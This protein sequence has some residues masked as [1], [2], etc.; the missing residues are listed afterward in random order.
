MPNTYAETSR[1]TSSQ[2]KDQ[3]SDM[4]G[5]AKEKAQEFGHAA[6][7]KIDEKRE[8]AADRLKGAAGGLEST[9]SYLREHDAKRILADIGSLVKRYPAQSILAAVTLGF[10]VGRALR[11]A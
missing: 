10:L 5:R 11:N 2:I 4:A 1:T 8:S 7:A 3:A 6:S 9:A